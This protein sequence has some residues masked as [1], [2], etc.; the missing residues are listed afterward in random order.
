M[1]YR[2]VLRS[3]VVENL[4]TLLFL[5]REQGRDVT[6]I[7]QASAEISRRLADNPTEQGESRDG[8]ERV[9]IVGPLTVFF[10]AFADSRTVL[11]YSAILY[12]GQ[13]C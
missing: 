11:I 6:P 1:N 4:E 9:L 7:R 8:N 2:V 10:E 13:R 5:G 12:P 3:R